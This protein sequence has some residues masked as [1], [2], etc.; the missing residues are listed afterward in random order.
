MKRRRPLPAYPEGAFLIKFLSDWIL[1]G[2][3]TG[4]RTQIVLDFV[5]FA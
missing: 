3:V 2:A 5:L 4:A 1:Y